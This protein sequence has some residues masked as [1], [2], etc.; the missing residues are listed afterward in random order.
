MRVGGSARRRSLAHLLTPRHTTPRA[1]F[2]PLRESACAPR[3][4]PYAAAAL[5][6]SRQNSTPGWRR[7]FAAWGLACVGA[8]SC[9]G[10]IGDGG[11]AQLVPPDA[12]VSSAA[13]RRLSVHELAQ[14]LEI[15]VGFRPAALEQLPP[16]GLTF[17]FDRVVNAQTFSRSHLDAYAA[18]AS[19]IAVRLMGERRLDDLVSG[20]PDAI[21]PPA[22]PATRATVLG[23]Q[24]SLGPDWSV[25]PAGDPNH[26]RTQFAPDPTAAYTHVF[27][28]PG[29]YDLSFGFNVVMGSVD[30][31]ELRVDGISTSSVGNASGPSSLGANV[32]IDAPGG[33]ALDFLFSTEPDDNALDVIYQEVV[34]DGPRDDGAG[35]YEAERRA[36]AASIVEELTPQIY[37]RPVSSDERARLQALYDTTEQADGQIVALRTLLEAIFSSPHFIFVVEVGEPTAPGVFALTDWEIASRL[38]YAICE[39]PP[40]EALRAAAAAGQLRDGNTRR[41]QAER[42]FGLPCARASVQRFFAQW[43]W[44]NRLPSLNKSQTD[45]PAYTDEVRAGMVAETERFIEALFYEQDATLRTLFSADYA[46]PD[47]RSAFLYG[48][49][50]AAA[51]DDPVP[52]PGHRA[53]VL[54]LPGTLAVTGSFEG[55]SP[56]R[57][58]VFV[59]EQLLCQHPPPP[60]ADL[61]I[62]PPLPDPEATTRERWAQH[63]ADGAC[64]SCH[65]T[66]DPIGFALEDFDGIGRH[67][68]EE[69]GLPVDAAGGVPTIGVADGALFGGAE[70]ARALADADQFRTCAAAQWLRFAT[71]RLEIESDRDVIEALA[72]RLASGSLREAFVAAITTRSFVERR[73]EVE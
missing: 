18:I 73:E 23:N 66:I 60:P 35:L 32:V 39:Q 44:L 64:R 47:A 8:A 6:W 68:T 61:D 17:S 50:V 58:G 43:L 4:A 48:E 71:G 2:L 72:G 65:A 13:I 36:C 52:L 27:P 21:V 38:S 5:G 25:I 7:W 9:T 29:S 24:L 22:V 31:L 51:G 70:L 62:V 63:S 30:T 49:G 1:A 20:C 56:V 10:D 67:R 14:T 34:I 26:R 3:V 53:G 59:L 28:S 16:D 12:E 55:T 54:T 46:W 11:G 40:D 57:R 33:H 42:L 37:R 15:T 41:A 19:E 45:F 69:N